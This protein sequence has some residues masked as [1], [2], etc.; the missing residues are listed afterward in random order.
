[1]VARETLRLCIGSLSS[2][3]V[4]MVINKV[5]A[6]DVR[7]LRSAVLGYK[8]VE[9][10][11]LFG[12]DKDD[13]PQSHLQAW[14]ANK[15]NKQFKHH[16]VVTTDNRRPRDD[17]SYGAMAPQAWRRPAVASAGADERAATTARACQRRGAKPRRR[18]PAGAARH[19]RRASRRRRAAAP[20]MGAMVNR[21]EP[22]KLDSGLPGITPPGITLAKCKHEREVNHDT[23]GA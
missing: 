3:A 6:S 9:F 4:P 21:A 2:S 22:A 15:F 12:R 5:L 1:V 14:M 7:H 10:P 19:Y 8:F 11:R 18:H 16:V 17:R 23:H 13:G 20:P